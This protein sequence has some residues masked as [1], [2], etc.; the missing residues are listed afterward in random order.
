MPTGARQPKPLPARKISKLW[1]RELSG[2]TTFTAEKR[3]AMRLRMAA[4]S[5]PWNS[6]PTNAPPCASSRSARVSA[7]SNSPAERA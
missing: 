6:L 1:A 3:P 5:G 4:K 7:S 2:F